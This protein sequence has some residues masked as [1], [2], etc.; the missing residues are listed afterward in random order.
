MLV[1]EHED[2]YLTTERGYGKADKPEDFLE[3]FSKFI[4][5]NQNKITALNIVCT[6]PSDL[7]RN[8]LKELMLILDQQGFNTRSLKAAWKATKNE[9]IA[10]DI[11][12]YIRTLAIGSS[13]ISHEDRIKRAVNEIRNM[14]AWNKVQLKWIDRFEKQLL[15]ETILRIEDLNEDP[16]DDAG[17]FDR[18]NKIFEDRLNE[19]VFKL[20]EKLYSEIA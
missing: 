12:S 14:Y 4:K 15:K 2:E 18:L 19:I 1:S 16:F 17:G 5:E 13:L 3:N 20:N 8:S 11:I 10:A 7:D 6:R 9:D